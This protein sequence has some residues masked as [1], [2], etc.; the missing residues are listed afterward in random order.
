M[1][2]CV[3]GRLGPSGRGAVARSGACGPESE[4]WPRASPLERLE[5]V[6]CGRRLRTA[7][8]DTSPVADE[9]FLLAGAAPLHDFLRR[10]RPA[11]PV[12]RSGPGIARRIS[13][14]RPFWSSLRVEPTPAPELE[15]AA[16][17]MQNPMVEMTKQFKN[18]WGGSGDS[19]DEIDLQVEE[20]NMP[21]WGGLAGSDDELGGMLRG[22]TAPWRV[23]DRL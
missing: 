4:G 18:L 17:G 10:R 11:D 7:V 6:V 15:A 20:M 22:L 5:G 3:G 2:C 21:P 14:F 16:G 19:E 13:E 23:S 12:P 9:S 8:E 1:H